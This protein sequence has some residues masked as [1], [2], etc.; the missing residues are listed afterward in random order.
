MAAT[1]I[2]CDVVLH[3]GPPKVKCDDGFGGKDHFVTDFIVCGA[4][5]VDATFGK[6][7]DLVSAVGVFAP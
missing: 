1:N 4:D 6:G 3:I 5:D 2:P 7:D